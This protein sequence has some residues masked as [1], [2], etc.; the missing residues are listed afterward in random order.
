[1]CEKEASDACTTYF[2]LHYDW[3]LHYECMLLHINEFLH[4]S[5]HWYRLRS[6]CIKILCLS[7][8]LRFTPEQLGLSGSSLQVW[9]T[10]GLLIIY[11]GLF[12]AQVTSQLSWMDLTC[13]LHLQVHQVG[14]I[15]D[16]MTWIAAVSLSSMIMCV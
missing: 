3:K 13:Q 1:M 10:K 6:Q 8:Q 11:L 14:V 15:L 2:F 7:F 5:M 4:C 12:L 9:L 16:H